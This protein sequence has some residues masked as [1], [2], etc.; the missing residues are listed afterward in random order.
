MSL[1]KTFQTESNFEKNGILLEYGFIDNDPTKPIRIKIA[2][3]GGSNTK[4][5]TK[6]EAKTKPFRRQIQTETLDP[7]IAEK[8]FMEIYAE[9]VILGW[10]NVQDENGDELA[11]NVANVVKL[12]TDLPDLWAD[13]KEQSQKAALF[14]AEVIE[15]D[16]GN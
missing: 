14:K 11:F 2:R 1:Y 16:A 8:L 3:A 4:Y 5:S 12:F 15:A 13:V 6:L 7:K 9:S 10:E